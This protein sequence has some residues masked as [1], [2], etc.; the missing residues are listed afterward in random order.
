ME[1][2]SSDEQRKDMTEKK[3][4]RNARDG[5]GDG[6]VEDGTAFERPEGF[7]IGAVDGDGDGMVQD[8]TEWERPVEEASVIPPKKKAA[9]S[10]EESVAWS[11][12]MSVSVSKLVY[13]SLFERNSRSVGLV[14]IRLIEQGYMSAGSDRRGW[15]SAGT[16]EALEQYATDNKIEGA[17][18]T[19]AVVRAL[20][21][22]TPVT[23]TG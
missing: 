23:V 2:Q 19:D 4:N 5:D 18:N 15:L 13:E 3:Q 1:K 17:Y 12:D 11:Q 14:Q 6:L 22:R 10:E 16:K 8:G 9:R 7:I 21:A 20:F